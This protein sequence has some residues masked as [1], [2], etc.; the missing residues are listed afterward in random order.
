MKHLMGVDVGIYNYW[1]WCNQNTR[2]GKRFHC[3][4]CFI[5]NGRSAYKNER[6]NEKRIYKNTEY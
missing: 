4:L 5:R 2:S 1:I 6:R 3:I